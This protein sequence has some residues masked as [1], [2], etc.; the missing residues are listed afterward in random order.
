MAAAHPACVILREK[1]LTEAQYD[2]L[3][4]LAVDI[5]RRHHV[6]CVLH[7]HV[8]VAMELEAQALH[9]P[10]PLLRGLSDG[11]REDLK[12]LGASCHS[13]E[14]A[15]EA[16]GLGATYVTAGHIFD[17]DCKAGLP[18]RGLLFLRRVVESVSIPV[19][20]IGG[21]TPKNIG[22]VR[23]TGAAG[24]CVM[25]GCMECADVMQY[26]RSFDAN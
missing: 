11:Q 6:V 22:A 3:A 9:L 23:E 4:R 25:S 24:A 8:D 1:D 13:V 14:E 20:A 10:M 12:I 16:E 26:I 19:Y 18:G 2:A 7:S 5:C 17:T 21:V 15:V